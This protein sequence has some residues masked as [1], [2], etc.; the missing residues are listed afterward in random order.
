MA[1]EWLPSDSQAVYAV[2]H[3]NENGRRARFAAPGAVR[4]RG[5]QRACDQG[6]VAAGLR[7]RHTAALAGVWQ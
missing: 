2:A 4:G 1:L 5:G 7:R 6:E 3:E